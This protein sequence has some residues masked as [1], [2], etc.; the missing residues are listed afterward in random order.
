MDSSR[1]LRLLRDALEA[2]GLTEQ[3]W[4]GELDRAKRRFGVCRYG[5][6]RISLSRHLVELNDLDH[7]EDTV[8]HEV[9]HALAWEEHGEHCGHDS[10]WREICI[11]IGARPERCFDGSVVRTP[12]G[13]YF[14]V[15]RETAEVFRS[16][17]RRPPRTD[18]SGQWIRGRKADT[19]G[20]LL[21]VSANELEMRRRRIA[22]ACPGV[23]VPG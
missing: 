2:H 13:S 1:A 5:P 6:R 18:R 15:H 23:Q 10:R 17:S 22:T 3:G 21:V 16:Y 11:R 12:R 7:V 19:Y 8:L 9:A 20:Q 4:T 14:L